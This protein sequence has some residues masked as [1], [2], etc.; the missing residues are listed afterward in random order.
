MAKNS[1]T[2]SGPFA[3]LFG[4]IGV[5]AGGAAGL[6]ANDFPGMC[7]GAL[8]LGMIGFVIGGL[9]DKLVAWLL[10]V[11]TALVMLLINAAI[12]HVVWD[13]L[14]ALSGQS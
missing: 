5:I 1:N 9:A 10:F 13:V 11:A 14:A 12:R 2:Q 7:V 6:Q 4:V 8:I 3:K